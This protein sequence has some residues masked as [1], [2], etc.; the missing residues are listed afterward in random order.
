MPLINTPQGN[1]RG[2]DQMSDYD[3]M[4]RFSGKIQEENC[5]AQIKTKIQI[6]DRD[7]I[8]IFLR[9]LCVN[10]NEEVYMIWHS[11]FPWLV[12]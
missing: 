11:Y 7:S 1:G 8:K 5:I 2:S 3:I 10:I 12:G 4:A 6:I 9:L